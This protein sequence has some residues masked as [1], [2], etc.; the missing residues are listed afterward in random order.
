[1]GCVGLLQLQQQQLLP[2]LQLPP[3]QQPAAPCLAQLQALPVSSPSPSQAPPTCPAPSGS[4]AG[5]TRAASGAL[6]RWML[7]GYM[8]MGRAT[9]A[10]V[11]LTATLTACLS[12]RFW[13]V[14]L[15]PMQGLAFRETRIQYFLETQAV[16]LNNQT[17]EIYYICTVYNKHA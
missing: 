6:P 10:S 12:Q 16:T 4:M 17:I 11:G 14:L 15:G 3:Q 2:H 8:S 13:R 5:R 7:R 9:M 1:M